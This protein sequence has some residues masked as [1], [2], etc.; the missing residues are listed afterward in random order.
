MKKLAIGLTVAAGLFTATAVP[1]MAQV[2]FYASPGGFG[3]ELGFQ[4]VLVNVL[5]NGFAVR[6]RGSL[7]AAIS[8]VSAGADGISAVFS[9]TVPCMRWKE[10]KP[11]MRQMRESSV[12]PAK[13]IWIQPSRTRRATA[14]AAPVWTTA[15]PQTARTR[16][17]PTPRW[18]RSRAIAEAF[19]VPIDCCLGRR[20]ERLDI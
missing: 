7:V 19:F 6:G 20:I 8:Q 2:D 16:P 14:G 1:A 18:R 15:G 11:V 12:L 3:V 9:V 17:P 5:E 10:S 13:S 4:A